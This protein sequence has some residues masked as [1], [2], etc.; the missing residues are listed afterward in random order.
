MKLFNSDFR[1]LDQENAFDDLAAEAFH[2]SF[3]TPPQRCLYQQGM[4][5]AFAVSSIV[6]LTANVLLG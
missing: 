1:I 5:H 2:I 4:V 6:A 3:E